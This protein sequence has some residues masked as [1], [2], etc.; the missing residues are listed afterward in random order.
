VSDSEAP[1]RCAYLV[2]RYP[3]VTHTF[4]QM[5]VRALRAAGVDI[6]TV[7]VRRAQPGD[8]LSP[9]DA[10]EFRTTHA[11]LPA[12]PVRVVA[13]HLRA[14]GRG[15]LAYLRILAA[16]LRL[17][18]GG[19]RAVLWQ[20]F[21][22]AEAAMLLAWMEARGLRHVHVHFANPAADVAMLTARLGNALGLGRWTW[23]LTIHGPTEFNDM[24]TSKLGAKVR[25]AALVVCTSDY[26]RS[27]VAIAAPQEWAK[28]RT[29]RSGIDVGAFSPDGA[30]T[31][32]SGPLE[33]LN[34]A[35]MSPRKGQALLL[36]A[37]AALRSRGLDVRLTIVGDGPERAG[38]EARRAELGLAGHAT[39]TGAVGHDEIH[40]H[41]RRAD[42]FCLPSF[43][44][45]VPTV[46][47]EAMASAVP[48]I[49]TYI[50]GVPEL[51]QDGHSGLLVSAGRA[52]ALAE[53]I[54]R[55]ADDPSL[56]ARLGA[57]GR[58]RVASAYELR[59]SAAELR[60]AFAGVLERD[61]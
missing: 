5:E 53:A 12:S 47:M 46:L 40:G 34:V 25:D 54:E 17:S 44:E 60:K 56:R 31:A 24:V 45:G 11:L 35:A 19:A 8:L 13:D 23:S 10:E 7:A 28:L 38:L 50:A 49:A 41:L 3:A 61:A 1:L 30:D 14:F 36:D 57:A 21:Y 9:A 33:V 43:A 20:L 6:H 4:V 22:F 15:P 16:A 29:V 32:R 37:V 42:V 39:F 18:V 48:V 55:L 52:D 51:V 58:K 26:A 2:S 59:R 27:Q